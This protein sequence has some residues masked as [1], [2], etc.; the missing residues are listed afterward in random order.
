[1]R[2]WDRAR[3]AGD[4]LLRRHQPLDRGRLHRRLRAQSAARRGRDRPAIR[5][6]SPTAMPNRLIV[7]LADRCSAATAAWSRGRRDGPGQLTVESRPVPPRSR[8]MP[9]PGTPDERDASDADRDRPDRRDRRG[10][11]R[12]AA[13][14][15]RRRRRRRHA[16]RPAVRPVRSA[17]APHLRDRPARLGRGADRARGSA[18]SSSST[19]SATAAATRGP[20]TPARTWSRSAISR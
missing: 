6:A 11:R 16:R 2:G 7:T 15:G 14:P 13:H 19:R 4:A 10:R 8:V 9:A 12:R 17:R 3:A 18:M 20:A 5:A 1:M